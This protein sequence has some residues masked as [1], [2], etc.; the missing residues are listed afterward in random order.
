[1]DWITALALLGGASSVVTLIGGA[2]VVYQWLKHR[3]PA[4]PAIDWP[5]APKTT[6]WRAAD[7]PTTVLDLPLPQPIGSKITIPAD[8]HE[9]RRQVEGQG[10]FMESGDGKSYAMR[11]DFHDGVI[12]TSEAQWQASNRR[13]LA[14]FPNMIAEIEKHA[15]KQWPE[16]VGSLAGWP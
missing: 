9:L 15:T 8:N 11:R 2:A 10:F 4:V 1:M 12:C 14:N 3:I 5:R 7:L 16:R 6:R 13:W